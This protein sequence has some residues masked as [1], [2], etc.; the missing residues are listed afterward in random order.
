MIRRG[1]RRVPNAQNS[2]KL[3]TGPCGP[4]IK[5]NLNFFD[6]S[7]CLF[8]CI[9]Y[10][11]GSL[12]EAPQAAYGTLD[13]ITEGSLRQVFSGPQLLSDPMFTKTWYRGGTPPW[14]GVPGGGPK[15]A[16]KDC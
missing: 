6:L 11:Q 14:G 13:Q 16:K 8:L 4:T 15:S 10:S 7:S 12:A 5:F 3:R 1:G 2:V 9:V